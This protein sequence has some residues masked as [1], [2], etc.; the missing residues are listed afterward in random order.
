GG[1]G[2][3]AA[4]LGV[5]GDGGERVSGGQGAQDGLLLVAVVGQGPPGRQAA[6]GEAAGRVGQQRSRRR[7]GDRGGGGDDRPPHRRGDAHGAGQARRRG[8]GGVV[9]GAGGVDGGAVAQPRLVGDVQVLQQDG[10]VVDLQARGLGRGDDA[11]AG[12]DGAVGAAQRHHEH[13]HAAFAA[14]VHEGGVDGGGLGDGGV[15]GVGG[16]L[17]GLRVGGGEHEPAGGGVVAGDGARR[18]VAVAAPGLG[19]Q[20]R[21]EAGH[22]LQ[23]VAGAAGAVLPGAEPQDGAERQGVVQQHHVEQ[24]G[25]GDRGAFQ[26]RAQ[27]GRVVQQ[28]GGGRRGEPGVP[29]PPVGQLLA[30]AGGE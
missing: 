3:G 2:G 9:E 30:F 8:P 10:G 13:E 28:L 15:G 4:G 23:R 1:V 14:A 17:G 27:R 7:P 18:Q 25:V 5:G 16:E 21:P 24:G 11:D 22:R 20:Q 29:Q 12:R 19:H 6:E 26:Q